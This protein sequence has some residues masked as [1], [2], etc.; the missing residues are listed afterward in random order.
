MKKLATGRNMVVCLLSPREF[1]TVTRQT[2]G[3]VQNGTDVDISWLET[4]LQFVE[5]NRRGLEA[6]LERSQNLS[7]SITEALK[8]EST[9]F[10]KGE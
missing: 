10:L 3:M 9:G 2:M 7:A 6:V 1:Q 5:S 4:S 8:T